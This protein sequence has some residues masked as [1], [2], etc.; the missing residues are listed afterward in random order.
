MLI[1][2]VLFLIKKNEE[3]TFVCVFTAVSHREHASLGME[4]RWMKLILESFTSF[5]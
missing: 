1:I 5:K 2:K 3:L 4:Q